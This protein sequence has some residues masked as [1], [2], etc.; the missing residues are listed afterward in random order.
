MSVRPQARAAPVDAGGVGRLR[1]VL[2]AGLAL[3]VGAPGAAAAPPEGPLMTPEKVAELKAL[4]KE[5]RAKKP[6]K[7]QDLDSLEAPTGHYVLDDSEDSS[8]YLFRGVFAGVGPT[9]YNEIKDAL[10]KAKEQPNQ[11]NTKYNLRKKELTYGGDYEFGGRTP[12]SVPLKDYDT[13][14]VVVKDS[15]VFAKAFA[16]ATRTL[17]EKEAAA[18][19]AAAAAAAAAEAQR[20]ASL[21]DGVH[22]NYYR[23]DQTSLEY[24]ADNEKAMEAGAPIVSVTLIDP[25]PNS[26]GKA[27]FFDIVAWNHA[28]KDKPLA[29]LL[30]KHGDV[31]VM[32]GN[33]QSKYKHGVPKMARP[34]GEDRV[35]GRVNVTARAFGFAQKQAA[36]PGPSQS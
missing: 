20:L 11:Y 14:P 24:H 31:L 15:V 5:M 4:I 7:I 21:Y 33:M 6:W 2:N 17:T 27:R 34:R 3:R 29:R 10:E 19:P 13:W 1:A 30:L 22:C 28:P 32:D 25:G 16:E 35:A 9:Q 36:P 23:D 8:V 18:K 12:Q 26:T